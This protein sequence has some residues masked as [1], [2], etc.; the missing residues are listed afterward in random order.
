MNR[1]LTLILLV[2]L[3]FE[4]G[5]AQVIRY[6][7]SA[8]SGIFLGEPL[9]KET[10]PP[11]VISHPGSQNFK[12]VLEPGA[13]LEIILPFS[14]NYEMGV[15]LGYDNYSGVTPTAPLYN[16]FLSKYNPMP[17]SH[18]YPDESMLFDTKIIKLMGTARLYFYSFSNDLN[19]FMKYFGGVA[20]TGSD[21]TFENPVDR[22][23][24]DVGVLFTRGTKNSDYPKIPALTGGAGLGATYR[25]S[26]RFDVYFD[27]TASLIHS[28]LV[29]GV[30]NFN[31]VVEV[32]TPRMER[33]NAVSATMQ[34]SVGIIYSAIP[35]RRISRNNITRSTSVNKN[36]F[37]NRKPKSS[38]NKKR[39]R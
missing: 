3:L 20:F 4:Q 7:L 36:K 12:P 29:N 6:R 35:D 25:L 24:Y 30:P 2:L 19:F 33:I 27:V 11:V 23:K 16:F 31:Y 10:A 28:D 18:K 15:Q 17:N 22:V 38:F 9:Q 13:E 21:F 34:G 8:N 39:R 1:N 5:T 32:E 14:R 37:L 26:D